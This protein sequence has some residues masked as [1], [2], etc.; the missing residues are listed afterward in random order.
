ME[1]LW[2]FEWN[3]TDFLCVGLFRA[4]DEEIESIYGREIYL[5]EIAGKHSDVSGT[6]ERGEI[7]LIS[8]DP[9]V[10]NAIPEIGYNPLAYL[11]ECFE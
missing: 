6:V 4:T 5:G 11:P 7:E 9:V 10:I 1:K 8:D 3:T 2:K